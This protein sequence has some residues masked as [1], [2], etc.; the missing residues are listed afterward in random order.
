MS[1]VKGEARAKAW[2]QDCMEEW[3]PGV[4]GRSVQGL[5]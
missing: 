4:E 1:Q 3:G 2:K 5:E